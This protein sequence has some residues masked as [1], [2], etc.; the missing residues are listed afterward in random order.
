[1]STTKKSTALFYLFIVLA[2]LAFTYFAMAKNNN[3]S[4]AEFEIIPKTDSLPEVSN[5]TKIQEQPVKKTTNIY[6]GL[7]ENGATKIY[8][9]SAKE[10]KLI[11][12]DNDENSKVQKTYGIVNSKIIIADSANSSYKIN[13]LDTDG[14]GKK[15]IFSSDIFSANAP[16]VSTDATLLLTT[17][18]SNAERDYGFGLF[19][20]NISG[21]NKR[22]ISP[23]ASSNIISPK[24][25]YDA[26]KIAYITT[27]NSSESKIFVYQ[28]SGSVATEIYSTTMNLFELAWLGDDLIFSATDSTPLK[29]NSVELYQLNIAEKTA[30]RITN[31]KDCEKNLLSIENDTNLVYINSSEP[32]DAISQIL[33]TPEDIKK[34]IDFESVKASFIV[35]IE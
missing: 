14:S 2:I 21:A 26:K 31:D 3:P 29:S 24:F 11:Y 8:L 13:M 27:K 19:M 20:Q 34:A 30:K 10:N 22:K 15:E 6:Y 5:L 28:N 17:T 7:S 23:T 18:F 1:M 9:K 12:R 35:G 32:Q 25:T 4:T 16:E 33:G